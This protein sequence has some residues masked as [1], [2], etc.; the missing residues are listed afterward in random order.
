MENELSAEYE[1]DRHDDVVSATPKAQM[2]FVGALLFG[3]WYSIVL[4]SAM[5]LGVKYLHPE[6]PA[7]HGIL[8]SIA[9]ALGSGIAIALASRISK[10]HR[11]IVGICSTVI[12]AGV[13]IGLL[14]FLGYDLDQPTGDSIFG[15][16]LS[17]KSYLFGLTLL[18]LVVGLASS[19]LGAES[20]ND[21]EITGSLFMVPNRHWLWLWIAASVW[22]SMVP[23]VLY[24][25]WL[26]FAIAL[27][28][29]IH[30]SLWFQLG[31]GLF[32]GF[33]GVA[34]LFKGI[35]VSLRAVSDRSS[36][37]GLVWKRVLMFLAGT[38]VLASLVSPF[39]LN[40]DINRLK[41]MP[42]S[43][44]SHPWWVL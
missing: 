11:W 29:T 18:I 4:A 17:V 16:E 3:A 12:S 15:H 41:D 30:P 37:G 1:I 26:Q 14:Y 35:E 10:N 34:A 25:L 9:W 19:F 28:S 6:T 38:L 13:W 32:F 24:Y 7:A 20:R 44:G 22:V 33:L 42:A 23:V 43:L 2:P 27:Y 8:Q 31:S 5:S 40:L 21:E 39:L 36:Y